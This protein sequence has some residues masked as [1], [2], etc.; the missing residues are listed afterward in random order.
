MLKML[1][2]PVALAVV[3]LLIALAAGA[4]E[5]EPGDPRQTDDPTRE[6]ADPV[7][8]WQVWLRADGHLYENFFQATAGREEEDVTA[9]ATELGAT[10][11]L[12]PAMPL[13]AYGSVNYMRYGEHGLG[14]TNG[15]RL[16]V[17]SEGRPHAFNAFVQQLNDRPTFDVGD[18][19]DRADVRTFAADYAYRFG[20]WQAGIDGELQSQRF[21]LTESRNNEFTGVGAAVRWRRWRVFS[22]EVGLRFGNRDVDD[23]TQSYDQRDAYLQ[24]R[25]SVTPQLYLSLRFR[26]RGREYTTNIA[27][28]SNF[29]R[30]DDRRQIAFNAV[31]SLRPDLDL[32]LYV[33][34]ENTDTNVPRRDFDTALWLLGITWHL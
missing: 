3:S 31:Y 16:G 9:F 5:I 11:A 23:P 6:R 17:R 13:L 32:N 20:E 19:F 14:S 34:R 7:A 12:S 30:E 28:A 22:P 26:D 1:S 21:Q 4:Q 8:A 24:I 10:Y 29:G 15:M 25:S 18:E 2:R 33:T 27:D